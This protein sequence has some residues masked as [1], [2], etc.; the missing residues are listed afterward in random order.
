MT[1]NSKVSNKLTSLALNPNQ[2]IDKDNCGKIK[3][4]GWYYCCTRNKWINY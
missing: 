4:G 1:M 3:G 2:V